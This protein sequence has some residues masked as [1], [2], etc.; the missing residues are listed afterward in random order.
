M[1]AVPRRRRIGVWPIIALVVGALVLAA[2]VVFTVTQRADR[3]DATAD[4]RHAQH[5]LREAR[6]ALREARDDLAAARTVA[7][8]TAAPVP[9]VLT[10]TQ[11]LLDLAGRGLAEAR[12]TQSLGATDDA[13][14]DEYNASVDRA[15]ALV[16]Q[17]NAIV[18][19]LKQQIGGLGDGSS[20]PTA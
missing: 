5:Q 13:S 9:P 10:S 14:I 15:N 18:D 17:Y 2:T 20:S 16:D 11:S 4:R 19:S 8:H 7:A 6:T 12:T 3:D 1:E